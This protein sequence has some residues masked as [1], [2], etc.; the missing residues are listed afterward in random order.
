VLTV[1]LPHAEQAKPRK[2]EVRPGEPA[3]T[4]IDAGEAN[5]GETS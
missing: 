3:R 4:A 5:T 2:I 1:R